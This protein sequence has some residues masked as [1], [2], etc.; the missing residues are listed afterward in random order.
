MEQ[1]SV[2]MFDFLVTSNNIDFSKW[3]LSERDITFVREA[4]LGSEPL[5]LFV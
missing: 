4:I 3:N 1:A 5:N 2:E